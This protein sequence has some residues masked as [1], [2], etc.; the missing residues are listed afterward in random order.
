MTTSNSTTSESTGCGVVNRTNC[1]QY[2]ERTNFS[3]NQNQDQNGVVLSMSQQ[4]EC[5]NWKTWGC[6]PCI[7]SS[8]TQHQFNV[9]ANGHDY[10][11][12]AVRCEENNNIKAN[13][14]LPFENMVPH[15]ESTADAV[16][17]KEKLLDTE[18]EMKIAKENVANSSG[19]VLRKEKKSWTVKLKT[20]CT[21]SSESVGIPCS[22]DDDS[23]DVSST[24]ISKN[25][26]CMHGHVSP[27]KYCLEE[28]SS[29]TVSSAARIAPSCPTPDT[30]CNH[31]KQAADHGKLCKIRIKHMHGNGPLV[32][33]VPHKPSYETAKTKKKKKKDK[34]KHP[35]AYGTSACRKSAVA[36][37]EHQKIYKRDFLVEGREG[38]Q[39]AVKALASTN[40]LPKSSK[41]VKKAEREI[42]HAL[43]IIQL[44]LKVLQAQKK[45]K[46]STKSEKATKK[47]KGAGKVTP[48]KKHHSW[49]PNYTINLSD[50]FPLP[51]SLTVR[52]GDLVPA[53]SM[54][55]DPCCPPGPNHPIWKWRLGMK[56][57][58][59][60][61]KRR[62][63]HVS[64]ENNSEGAS[65]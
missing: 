15:G 23:N 43:E 13:P 52:D 58:P 34:N 5:R 20:S 6:Q 57:L 7:V 24:G 26:K 38:E 19:L 37:G 61:P 60:P 31:G 18:S 11:G 48:K 33:T 12:G 39:A 47:R 1:Y 30:S 14:S 49:E 16:V 54:R 56:P 22:K 17:G 42:A 3:Q 62:L 36:N 50:F 27:C 46:S 53:C 51:P 45:H 40:G 21:S 63:S 55:T 2:L 28:N 41:S 64:V 32:Q 4:N 29:Q 44:Q 59:R 65:R 8:T 10:L 9:A 25:N 35:S